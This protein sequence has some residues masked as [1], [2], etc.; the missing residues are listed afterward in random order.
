MPRHTTDSTHRLLEEIAAVF[1]DDAPYSAAHTR[2]ATV[3][4]NTVAA[5]LADCLG[6]NRAAAAP[7]TTDLSDLALGLHAAAASLHNGLTRLT[8][9]VNRG[10]LP[11]DR[12]LSVIQLANLRATLTHTTRTLHAVAV[13]LGEMHRQTAPPP[14]THQ[15]ATAAG[16]AA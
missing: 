9:A 11:A 16:S 14:A 2:A 10:D 13:G 12:Q 8:T 1:D 7:T 5:Y 6:P 3:A 15:P 4:L